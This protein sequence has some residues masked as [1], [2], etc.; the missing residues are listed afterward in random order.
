MKRILTIVIT[1][2]LC[3]LSSLPVAS[4][5]ELPIELT[6]HQQLFDK[7]NIDIAAYVE[8][9]NRLNEKYGTEFRLGLDETLRFKQTLAKKEGLPEPTMEDLLRDLPSPEEYEKSG[10]EHAVRISSSQSAA[11]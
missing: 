9:D 3:V 6:K 11:R 8:I 10:F 1:M 7:F 2:I 4:P 5:T